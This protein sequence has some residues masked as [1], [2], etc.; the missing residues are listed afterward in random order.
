MIGIQYRQ[1]GSKGGETGIATPLFVSVV[2]GFLKIYGSSSVLTLDFEIV[3]LTVLLPYHISSSLDAPQTKNY[4]FK[5]Y[6]AHSQN[7]SVLLG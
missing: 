7:C 1:A 4:S 5:I 3:L 6:F 2:L